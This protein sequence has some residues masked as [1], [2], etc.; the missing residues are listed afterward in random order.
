MVALKEGG[1]M[2]EQQ[3][4]NMVERLIEEMLANEKLI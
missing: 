3:L 4:K 2:D 1:Q